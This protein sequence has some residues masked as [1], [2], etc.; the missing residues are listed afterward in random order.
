MAA[1]RTPRPKAIQNAQSDPDRTNVK[2][3][4]RAY[5][6]LRGRITRGSLTPGRWYLQDELA[7]MLDL[8]RTPVREAL[9]RLA[10]EGWVVIRPR[11]GVLVRSISLDELGEIYEAMTALES[12]A[13]MCMAEHGPSEQ[14][15]ADL[16]KEQ[17][18]MEDAFDSDD[19]QAWDHANAIFHGHLVT[20]SGNPEL[21][22][23]ADRL[24]ERSRKALEQTAPYRKVPRISNED[25]ATVLAHI[26][27]RDAAGAFGAHL[28]HCRR[29][30][31]AVLEVA[32]DRGLNEL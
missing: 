32:R 18:R 20:G 19:I 11:R 29:G 8:S 15:L 16:R 22:A 23:M 25:H 27:R 26:E 3:T 31:G 30:R 12:Y 6:S 14:V 21:I 9:I 17:R 24:R 1:Q 4:D 7:T 28:S 13:V 10:G 5:A 2:A